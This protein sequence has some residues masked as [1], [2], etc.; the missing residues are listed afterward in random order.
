[1]GLGRSQIKCR[2]CGKEIKDFKYAAMPEWDVSEYLCGI[3][4]SKR[5]SEYYIKHEGKDK[6]KQK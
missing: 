6:S 2:E 5:L 3:C 4:Y 1:M